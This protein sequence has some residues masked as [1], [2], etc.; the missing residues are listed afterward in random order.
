MAYLKIPHYFLDIV[1]T[2]DEYFKESW[3]SFVRIL[4]CQAAFSG[5]IPTNLGTSKTLGNE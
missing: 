2:E 4:S 3:K 1:I 5:F